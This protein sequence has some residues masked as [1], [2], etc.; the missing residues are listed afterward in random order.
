MA[1]A[2]PSTSASSALA[3]AFALI[4][5]LALNGVPI[6][7][8][9]VLGW[10]WGTV[11]VLYCCE[12]VLG[13]F[14][15]ALRMILHRRLTHDRGYSHSLLGARGKK[16]FRAVLLEFVGAMLFATFVHGLFL[17]MVLGLMLK[18][19]PG[20]AVHLAAL[21]QGLAA[22]ALIMAGS[23]ALDCQKL[24]KLPFTWIEG[25][26]QRSLGRIAVIQLALILGGIG[27]GRYGISKAPFAVFAIVKLL[28]DLGGLYTGRARPKLT[29]APIPA[30][31]V[32]GVNSEA[33][34]G[35][36]RRTGKRRG[37]HG[38]KRGR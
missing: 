14:F 35:S 3:R 36:D 13:T 18:G 32:G 24:R 21:R 8:V 12:T 5:V 23:L 25:L 16:P 9:Y 33:I 34:R 4:Q 1:A 26:A 30:V 31:I 38:R 27:I 22:M 28:I 6:Y 7:G 15:L 10:S 2:P 20:A 11:L 19:Q 17:G 29:P 37:V